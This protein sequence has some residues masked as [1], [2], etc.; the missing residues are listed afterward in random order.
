[1]NTE[2]Y[3][4]KSKIDSGRLSVLTIVDLVG[5][6]TDNDIAAPSTD[7]MRVLRRRTNIGLA[8]LSRVINL[9]KKA[10]KTTNSIINNN[11]LFPA[12]SNITL[13]PAR[14]STLT[15]VL[16]PMLVGN[17]KLFFMPFIRDGMLAF[18]IQINFADSDFINL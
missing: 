3:I 17:T 14:E 8:A 4:K 7:D 6:L 1:M 15:S 16:T 12:R 2:K 11:P 9:I 10:H 5:K 18:I 13:T